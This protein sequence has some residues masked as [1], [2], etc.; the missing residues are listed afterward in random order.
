MSNVL[1][2]KELIKE[3]LVTSTL[4]DFISEVGINSINTKNA[5]KSD[6]Q[7]YIKINISDNEYVTTQ[8]FVDSISRNNV[9]KYR[10]IL[11]N[12]MNLSASSINRKVT[13]LN[14]FC[15]FLYNSNYEIDLK[16]F[17]SLKKIKGADNSYEVILPSEA[18]MIAEYLRDNEKQ[19]AMSK[20]YYCLLAIDTG[21]RAEA[22]NNLTRNSFVIKDEN[23]VVV[24]GI[25]KGKKTFAKTI[26]KGFYDKM[27]KDLG[28]MGISKE[29]KIFSYS[30][31]NRSTMM[32]RAKKALGWENR[33]ITFHSFKK[34][35]VTFAF[36]TTKDILVAQKVGSHS[37]IT[38]TERYLK[39]AEDDFIGAVSSEF[40][41]NIKDVDLE[42]YTKEDLI[43][44]IMNTNENVS[45]L[46]KKELIKLEK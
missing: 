24:K 44:A 23:V 36:D 8:S 16:V 25:D 45:Y 3:E 15:K 5:Y 41:L 37:S 18:L 14:E 22:L 11:L 40:S 43:K 34:C 9:M 21:I 4:N 6:I 35:A 32:T 13:A 31:K 10:N 12:E 42:N 29:D 20:Y 2:I 39:G 38:T 1:Q 19:N 27:S 28:F 26:D 17:A 30:S 46:V 7:Q 33:N